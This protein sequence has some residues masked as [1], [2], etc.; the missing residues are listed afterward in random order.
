MLK[1]K[2]QKQN[3]VTSEEVTPELPHFL[4]MYA[5]WLT[6]SLTPFFFFTQGRECLQNTTERQIFS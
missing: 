2:I 3:I 6:Q 1:K 4:T 5:P